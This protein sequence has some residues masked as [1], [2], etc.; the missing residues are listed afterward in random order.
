MS[1]PRGDYIRLLLGEAREELSKADAKVSTLLA[2]VGIIAGIVAGAIAAGNWKPNNLS[3]WAQIVWWVGVAIAMAGVVALAIALA[4]RISH[5]EDRYAIH[6]FGHVAQFDSL[7]EFADALNAI[8]RTTAAERI[9]TQLWLVSRIVVHKYILIRYGFLA[10]GV[11]SVMLIAG[12]A[13]G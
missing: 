8:S 9:E 13:L 12:A 7:K 10:F 1:D 11:A 6:Y 4:P 5:P 2:T 3:I